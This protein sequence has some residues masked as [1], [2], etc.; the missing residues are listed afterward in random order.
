MPERILVTTN[1]LKGRFDAPLDDFNMDIARK[2]RSFHES[3]VQYRETPLVELKN[4]AERIGLAG[5]YV[6]DESHRFGLNAFKGLGGSYAM[7]SYIADRL[8]KSVSD[9]PFEK[10]ASDEVRKRLDGVMTFAIAQKHAAEN[11][12]VLI[13]DTTFDDYRQFPLWCMQGYTTLAFEVYERFRALKEKP[14][15]IFIQAGSGGLAGSVA[16][17]FRS[18]C[19]KE[20]PFIAVVESDQA[21]AMRRTAEADDGAIHYVRGGLDSVSSGLACGEPCSVG[22]EVLRDNA[23]TFLACDD[24]VTVRGMRVLGNPLRGDGQIISGESGAA[25]LGVVYALMSNPRHADLAKKLRLD[26]NA[27]VLCISTEGDT[28]P[29]RYRRIVWEGDER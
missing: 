24:T 12:W 9:L 13:Q 5:L 26:A 4:L 18:V 11:G 17:F 29:D 10:L 2:A 1:P 25:G 27:S 21:D 15:H 19:G 6:K 16:G 3:N 28:T 22:W 8:G 7:A 20:Q 14:T 23:D